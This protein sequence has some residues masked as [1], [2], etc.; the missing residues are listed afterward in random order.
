MKYFYLLFSM[1][2]VSGCNIHMVHHPL[3]LP[4]KVF[5]ETDLT[6]E[7]MLYPW[8]NEIALS[9][10]IGNDP[11]QGHMENPIVFYLNG[12]N[13]E[14]IPR[15]TEINGRTHWTYKRPTS[16]VEFG[17]QRIS[18]SLDKEQLSFCRRNQIT[19]Y[20]TKNEGKGDL[21]FVF[22]PIHFRE[23][24]FPNMQLKTGKSAP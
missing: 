13:V 5:G 19:F 3:V 24:L 17:R 22:I 15:S 20:C 21:S 16:F 7:F 9:I 8:Q 6:Y 14:Q 2:L 18:F 12:E 11:P 1:L 23:K 10:D 4:E